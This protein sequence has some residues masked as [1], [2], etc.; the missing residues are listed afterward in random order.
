M[1]VERNS[2][3]NIRQIVSKRYDP[4]SEETFTKLNGD[5][6]AYRTSMSLAA[7]ARQEVENEDP[8]EFYVNMILP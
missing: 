5:K 2:S 8:D 3:F 1:P 7:Q 4:Q 6:E